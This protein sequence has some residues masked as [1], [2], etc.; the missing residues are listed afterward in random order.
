[1]TALFVMTVTIASLCGVW[2]WI[3]PSPAPIVLGATFAANAV[4]QLWALWALT[5]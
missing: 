2:G 4:V 1:M 5:R 3:E